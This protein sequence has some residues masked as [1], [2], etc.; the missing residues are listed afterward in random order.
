MMV[1]KVMEENKNWWES[2]WYKTYE[3]MLKS[4]KKDFTLPLGQWGCYI[5]N[6]GELQY[7]FV[8]WKET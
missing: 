5:D 8:K 1:R 3:K 2:E 6:D 7:K 4:R